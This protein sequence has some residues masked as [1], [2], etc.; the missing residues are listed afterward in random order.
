[1][2]DMNLTKAEMREIY[3]DY[4]LQQE[5]QQIFKEDWEDRKVFD[6]KSSVNVSVRDSPKVQ[7]EHDY[8]TSFPEGDFEFLKSLK[9][10]T[11]FVQLRK[12]EEKEEEYFVVARSGDNLVDREESKEPP[13][14]I[15]SKVELSE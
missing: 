1:M 9:A 8:R 10:S 3:R 7:M 12:P 4:R 14:E 15:D 13:K 6:D 2:K 11:R 5:L